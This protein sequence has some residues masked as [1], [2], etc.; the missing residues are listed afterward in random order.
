MVRAWPSRVGRAHVPVPL[1]GEVALTA[2]LVMALAFA[3]VDGAP[4]DLMVDFGLPS[5][6]GIALMQVSAN[7]LSGKP[8]HARRLPVVAV[9]P[10][11]RPLVP[12]AA[13]V[14]LMIPILNVHRPVE[15]VGVDQWGTLK[16]PVNSWN[17]GWYDGGPVPGAPGDAV[18]EG[19]AGY[20]GQP[21][22]FAKLGTL[23]RGDRIIVVLADH[24]QRLFIVVSL[25]KIPAGTV[26]D[27]LAEPSG[28]P[29][30]TLI[31]CAGSFDKKHYSYSD[32]LLV[33]A[34]YA[35]LA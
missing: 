16:L 20:P 14:F 34:R 9:A 28:P 5:P 22:L 17:A 10:V 1:F 13:P 24:T 7:N 3:W 32:R 6:S 18:I 31:T 15:K 2:A 26:P 29:R 21:V 25:T 19:H 35:G 30:L 4:T 12:T 8:V 11:P 23:M 33:Y 27:G